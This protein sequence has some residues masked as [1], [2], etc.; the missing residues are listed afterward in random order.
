MP[1]WS[2]RLASVRSRTSWPSTRTAPAGHVV[3]AGEQPGRR[4]TCRCP[5]RADE[6]RPS[7]PAR[8]VQVEAVE[9]GRAVRRTRTSRR[10]TARRRG[11]STQVDRARAV[12]DR[13]AAR[14]GPRRCAAADA[15]A[16]WPI[17]RIMP[18]CRNGGCS[19]QH[20]GV[21]G[22]D[23]RRPSSGRRS[24]AS[25]RRAARAPG[26]SRGRFSSSGDHAAADVGVLHVRPLGTA[27]PASVQRAAA[28]ASSAANDLTTRTPLMF[29]STTVATSASRAW[30]SHD[31]GNICLRIAHADE[32][33][34]RHGRHRDERQR[35]VDRQHHPRTRRTATL[36]CTRIDR[37]E[38]QVHLHR[39]DVGVGPRDQLAGLHP[40]VERE[41]HAGC[42]CS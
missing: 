30:M 4:S 16:R 40:V 38:R 27:S 20:V 34:E 5:V 15:A 10:R 13:R 29:S 39:A 32:V 11:T 19:M 3:E 37:R 17:I 2:R 36:H 9:H 21:E 24:R 31:T 22:D 14:R 1:T 42:R 28:G 23:R 12:D 6:R 33:D 35:H 26:P 8:S 25:R 7:R 18:S 41:R